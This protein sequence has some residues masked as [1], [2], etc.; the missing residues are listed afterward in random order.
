MIVRSCRQCPFFHPMS[1]IMSLL[2]GPFKTGMCNYFVEDDSL[3]V[4]DLVM[5]PGPE[6]DAMTA[7]ARARLVIDDHDHI[8]EACPLHTRDITI[9]LGH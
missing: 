9:S 7:R 3:V 4:V 6:R 2:L 5:P 8:P 1:G